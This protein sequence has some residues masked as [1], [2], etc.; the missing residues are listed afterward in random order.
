MA[1]PKDRVVFITGA[2]S[3]IGRATA[4][5]FLRDGARVSVCARREIRDLE[6]AFALR[7]DV[8]DRAQVRKTIDAVVEKFGALHVL[9]NNAGFGVY[10]PIEEIREDDFEDI[11]RTNVFGPLHCVQ[12][13]LPHLKKT[14]GQ[15]IN[16]SSILARSTVPYVVAY[17]MTKHALHSFSE[18]LRLELKPHGVRVIEIGPG[19]TATDFQRAAKKTGVE[20]RVV[21]DNQAGWPPA[22]VAKAILHASMCGRREVWLT[23]SGKTLLFLHD[24]FPRLADWG[25]ERWRKA[26]APKPKS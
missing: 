20:E 7:C 2:S 9:V 18:G 11:F 24:N 8:R 26:K 16:I 14:R 25:L 3:G 1:L 23:M 5:A 21:P 22:R 12:A 6:G 13:A 15:V 19:L 4:E 17:C 10:A